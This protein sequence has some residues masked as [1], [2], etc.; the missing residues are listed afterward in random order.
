M[1]I[2]EAVMAKGIAMHCTLA[3]RFLERGFD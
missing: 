2:E 1:T 3:E